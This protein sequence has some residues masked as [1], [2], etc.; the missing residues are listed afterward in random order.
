MT[1]WMRLENRVLVA[2]SAESRR[3][4]VLADV[5]GRL[6][7]RSPRIPFTL[8]MN[9]LTRSNSTGRAQCPPCLK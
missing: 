6:A 2:D 8:S 1:I 4:V 5:G 9:R 3:W 7:Y